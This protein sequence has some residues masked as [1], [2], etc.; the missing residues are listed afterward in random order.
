MF[1]VVMREAFPINVLKA[2][3]QVPEVVGIFCATANPVQVIVVE[4]EQGRGIAGV[5]DGSS[6]LDVEQENH[7]SERQSFLRKIGYKR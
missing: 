6:P 7:R 2:V 3:Q 4:T 1:A 5:I